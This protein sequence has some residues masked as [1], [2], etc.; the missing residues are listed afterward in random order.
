[1]RKCVTEDI[2]AVISYLLTRSLLKQRRE[3]RCRITEPLSTSVA[4]LIT[5]LSLTVGGGGPLSV[6][7]AL[8]GAALRCCSVQEGGLKTKVR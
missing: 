6:F 1:M 2:L 4:S 8:C 5:V 3:W 7:G